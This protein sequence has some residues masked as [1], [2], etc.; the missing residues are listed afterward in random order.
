MRQRRRWND[1]EMRQRNL[2]I[3]VCLAVGC[4]GAAPSRT[5][6][7]T[8]GAVIEASCVT[9]NEDN[10]FSWGQAGVD[11][12]RNNAV[13]TADIQDAAVT[14]TK[15]GT[16]AVTT[17]VILDG[18]ITA[19]DLNATLTFSDGDLINLNAINV[20]S[21]EG[22]I[23]PQATSCTLG[24]SE[25]QIC[26]DTND[27]VLFIGD[28]TTARGQSQ[29]VIISGTRDCTA[30]G[31]SVAY[32][33]AGFKPTAL[34]CI[35]NVGSAVGQTSWGLAV[36]TTGKTI[37]DEHFAAAGR[38]ALLSDIIS[39]LG[40]TSGDRCSA[41]VSAMGDDGFTLSWVKTGT[42][43]GTTDFSCMAMR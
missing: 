40:P 30:A 38:Y 14:A 33:G 4:F 26:W 7:Y 29:H 5:C 10:I 43:T 34:Y 3:L 25:G 24:T 19:D 13:E 8:T 35:A 42:P 1:L 31:G 20:S 17:T 21:T 15:L 16:G 12:I 37:E 22:L 23:L 39:L 9:E 2:A 27:D 6:T 11:N 28:G 32:T 41:S 36:G 18:T